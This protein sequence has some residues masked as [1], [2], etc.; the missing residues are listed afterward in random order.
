MPGDVIET[1]FG[2]AVREGGGGPSP[3]DMAAYPLNDIGNAMRLIVLAGGTVHRNGNVDSTRSTLLHLLGYGWIG[4]NGVFWDRKFGEE[5]A[6]KLA[7]QVAHRNPSMWPVFEGRMSAKEFFKFAT[8][9]GSAGKTSAMLRQAQSYLMVEIDAFDR[10]PLALTCLN[11]TLKMR[12]TVGADGKGTFGVSLRPHDQADRITRCCEADYDPDATA[13]LFRSVIDVSLPDK[14]ERAYFKQ[15][16]GYAA[17]GCTHEQVF[18]MCQGR[19]RDGKSTI[20]D[21]CREALGSYGLAASPDTFLEGGMRSGSDAA[22][23]LIALSG[24]TRFAILSEPKRGS[25][26]NE[27]LLKAWTSGSPISARDLHA[28]PINFRPKAKLIFEMNAFMVARGDDDG[29][30]RRVRPVLFRRQVPEDEMDRLLPEKLRV[31]RSGILNWLIEGVGDWLEVGKLEP[32]VSLKQVVEDYRR[33]SSPFGDWL[34]E[35]CFHGEAAGGNR[36]LTGDLYTSFK[37]WSEDAGNDRI[38][39]AKAFGDALRDRQIGVMGKNAKGLKYRGP[40]R[41]KTLQER[42]ADTDA[43]AVFVA[44]SGAG[45][46]GAD[47]PFDPDDWAGQ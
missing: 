30:W 2:M 8:D 9:S 4:F 29:I 23:D 44:P 31:E 12:W 35:F 40:I 10:D 32:P 42:L 43:A 19:G 5:L 24:D 46:E 11:G 7:H 45:G 1:V 36:E 39:S 18:I 38:M 3:E 26:M 6:R 34:A 25:K 27:G 14:G 41:L 47:S 20:L 37:E 28:K 22:P 17:T 33:A 21:A 16:L 13:A 15:V